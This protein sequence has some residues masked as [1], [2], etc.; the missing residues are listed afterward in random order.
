M[1]RKKRVWSVAEFALFVLSDD[2]KAACKRALRMLNRLDVK[3]DG[4]V[5][6]R[7]A[8]K[9][10]V[11]PATLARLEADLFAPIES[12]EFRVEA[13][14]EL[15]EEGLERLSADNRCLAAQTAQNTRDI[16]KLRSRGRAA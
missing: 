3:H 5:L 14:E 10:Y 4:A 11:Y 12:L 15:T 13:L 9:Y 7:D 16:S 6:H 1:S 8:G 2:S